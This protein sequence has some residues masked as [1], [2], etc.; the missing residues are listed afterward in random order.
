[1][2]RYEAM[3]AAGALFQRNAGSLEGLYG[4]AVPRPRPL[5][6]MG[7][8]EEAVLLRFCSFSPRISGK[9]ERC[10]GQLRLRCGLVSENGIVRGPC[11]GGGDAKRHDEHCPKT[12]GPR[13]AGLKG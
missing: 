7:R 10:G 4:P 9:K 13:S 2:E 8:R 3:K 11:A 5:Y 1:M 12:L 6:R